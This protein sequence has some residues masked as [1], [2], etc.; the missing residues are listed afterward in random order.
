MELM[1][2]FDLDAFSMVSMTA[3]INKTPFTPQFLGSLGIFTRMPIR[4]IDNAVAITD[5]G[6]LVIVQTTPR[7]ATPI[8][9][10][11]QGQRTDLQHSA[12]VP[13]VA[14]AAKSVDFGSER[15]A[16]NVRVVVERGVPELVEAMDRGEDRLSDHAPR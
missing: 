8:E 14:T 16:R 1:D 3:A 10:M 13:N 9:R 4:T 11:K 7:A 6:N 2:I 5:N 12:P 15:A